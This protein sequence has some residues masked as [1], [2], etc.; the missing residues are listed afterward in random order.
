MTVRARILSACLVAAVAPLVVFAF[1]ARREMSERVTAQYRARVSSLAQVITQDLERRSESID[2]HLRALAARLEDDGTLR[3]ALLQDGNRAAVLDYA[4]AIMP[5]TGLDYLLLL[6]SEGNVLSSGHF[7]NEYGRRLTAT[8][9]LL[10]S[11]TPILVSARAPNA[12]FLAFARA[13]AFTMGGRRFVLAGGNRVDRAFI[14]GLARDANEGLAV[15]LEYPGGL[16]ASRQGSRGRAGITD[17]LALPFID[18]AGAAEG[19]AQARFVVTHSL[20]QLRALLRR[21]DGWFLAGSAGALLLAV[22]IAQLLAARVN[23]PL[24]ELAAKSRRVDLD[25]LDVAFSTDR[26]DEIG[27]LSRL[28][29]GMMHRLRASAAQLR[30]AERRATVGDMA[31]QVNHDIKNGLLPIRNV[32]RHLSDVAHSS[33]DQLGPVFTERQGT[34]DGGIAY[35]EN[36]ASNYARLAP[37]GERVVLD[38][39]DVI[40]TVARLDERVRTSLA[41]SAPRVTADPVALRRVIENLVVN[42]LESLVN[43]TGSVQV[44]SRAEHGDGEARVVIEVSDDGK[45]IDPDVQDRIFDDFYSTKERGSGLGLSIVRRLMG[46]M[47]GRVRV[48][49]EPGRGSRF[50][51]ELPEAT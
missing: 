36:L 22:L 13:H 7:R 4:S 14:D 51:I 25:R 38:V 1:G 48:Q 41:E 11:R 50:T 44:T 49:S 17:E 34:L 39:N 29:D 28:L 23:R 30:D 8:E 20:V 6:D 31:R 47:G 19:Q 32:I 10:T 45:G 12:N 46:D 24:E 27:S 21:V 26:A 3:A 40:R 33:P 18:D 9:T 5:A 35:L 2:G 43:G 15:F 16:L 37:R 42:A